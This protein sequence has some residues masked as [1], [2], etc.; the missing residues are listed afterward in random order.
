M[1]LGSGCFQN[2]EKQPKNDQKIEMDLSSVR[3]NLLYRCNSYLCKTYFSIA[4][5]NFSRYAKVS[6]STSYA[7]FSA[8]TQCRKT[9]GKSLVFSYICVKKNL[10]SWTSIVYVANPTL[11][12]ICVQYCS[13]PHY[14]NS[15]SANLYHAIP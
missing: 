9:W 8:S 2:G 12:E 11:C 1:V 6:K 7:K 15:Q 14:A 10:H 5:A 3:Q 4:Y 13:N